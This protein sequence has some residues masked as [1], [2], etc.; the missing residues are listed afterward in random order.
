MMEIRETDSE[1]MEYGYEEDCIKV[2]ISEC[3]SV[4]VYFQMQVFLTFAI[5]I[6]AIFE[7]ILGELVKDVNLFMERRNTLLKSKESWYLLIIIENE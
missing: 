6:L 1:W 7:D 5:I 3:K 4:N 2:E